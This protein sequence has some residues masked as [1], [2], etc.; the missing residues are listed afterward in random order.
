MLILLGRLKTFGII[1]THVRASIT[2]H[3]Q[4]DGLHATV[5]RSHIDLPGNRR[6]LSG[7]RHFWIHAILGVGMGGRLSPHQP[8][9]GGAGHDTAAG[10][11]GSGDLRRR[12]PSVCPTD[13][14][15]LDRNCIS[16]RGSPCGSQA[17]HG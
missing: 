4:Q 14:R 10:N 1:H 17:G 12:F 2:T 9:S 7:H 5:G 8:D 11:S 13:L 16:S 6:H 15:Q 3:G